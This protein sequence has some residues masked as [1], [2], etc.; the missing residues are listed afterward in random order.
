[1]PAATS[2]EKP[3]SSVEYFPVGMSGAVQATPSARQW[4]EDAVLETLRKAD[5]VMYEFV[6]KYKFV[7][8]ERETG[9]FQHHVL[10]VGPRFTVKEI[11]GQKRNVLEIPDFLASDEAAMGMAFWLEHDCPEYKKW[12]EAHG[13]PSKLTAVTDKDRNATAWSEY[14]RG[15]ATPMEYQRRDAERIA[16]KFGKE[17]PSNWALNWFGPQTE[18]TGLFWDILQAAGGAYVY[19]KQ[20]KAQ[21]DATIQ[22]GKPSTRPNVILVQPEPPPRPKVMARGAVNGQEFFDVNQGARPGADAQKPTI[23]ADRIAAKQ[24]KNPGKAF[25]NMAT[26]HAEIGLIQQAHEAGKTQGADMTIT[27]A[28]Q[29]VCGYCMGDIPAAAEKAGLK[30]LTVQDTMA[31]KTYYWKKGMRT[32][33]EMP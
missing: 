20:A 11:D 5:P 22:S 6:K 32:L 33:K 10:G 18:E 17:L 26:A 8:Q 31:G 9:W 27:V 24:A 2:A 7:L 12:S 13:G 23:I 4:D 19:P 1:V 21:I 16:A 30:S 28:G 25:P 15:A 29:S 14:V 3:A